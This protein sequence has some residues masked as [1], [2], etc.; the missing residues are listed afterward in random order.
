MAAFSHLNKDAY[1]GRRG[2]MPRG[3][4]GLIFAAIGKSLGAISD[5]LFS[6]VVLRGIVTTLLGHPAQA[7]P[8]PP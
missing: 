8:G 4:V 3:K 2:M 7:C 6:A 1:R 5:A